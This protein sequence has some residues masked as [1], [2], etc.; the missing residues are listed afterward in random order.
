MCI[1]SVQFWIHHFSLPKCTFYLMPNR[2]VCSYWMS[3]NISL[4]FSRVPVYEDFRAGKLPRKYRSQWVLHHKLPL[5]LFSWVFFFPFWS[6][7]C[8]HFQ[9]SHVQSARMKMKVTVKNPA[10]RDFSTLIP[11][12]IIKTSKLSFHGMFP[13]FLETLLINDVTF[14]ALLH[15]CWKP[16]ISIPFTTRGA[17][18][19]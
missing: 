16:K 15:S 18:A 10:R 4:I 19:K 12:Y 6:G 7:N 13:F 5:A 8:I 2:D 3:L 14:K 1:Y 11:A 17:D 9:S